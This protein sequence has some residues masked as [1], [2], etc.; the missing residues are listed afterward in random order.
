[1]LL[2]MFWMVWERIVNSDLVGDGSRGECRGVVEYELR[3]GLP[4]IVDFRTVREFLLVSLSD[5]I[6]YILRPGLHCTTKGLRGME[7]RELVE[8][9]IERTVF[10]EK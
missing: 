3:T 6:A 5:A 4:S 7:H 8:G 9:Q 10:L 2:V 1:M